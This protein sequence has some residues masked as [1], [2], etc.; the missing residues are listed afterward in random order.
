VSHEVQPF[1]A[2]IVANQ[3]ARPFASSLPAIDTGTVTSPWLPKS[4]G[5]PEPGGTSQATS[6]DVEATRAEAIAAGREEGLAE[7]AKL[8]AQLAAALDQI[9]AAHAALAKPASDMIAEAAAAIVEAWSG[10]ADRAVVYA[11]LVAAWLSRDH[12]EAT[13]RVHPDDVAAMREAVG[14][15]K[16]TIV[17]DPGVASGD[18]EFLG[19]A[20]ELAHRW[21]DRL[22]ELRT[23]IAS[24][25]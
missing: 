21:K 20:F 23:A 19:E 22:D 17:G 3:A 9:V 7:T 16:L 5:L 1:L 13:V 6:I 24:A 4:A 15:A 12:G 11:P 8:R 14:D 18:A 10:A 2:V 25:L